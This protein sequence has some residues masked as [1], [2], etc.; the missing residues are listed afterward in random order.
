M[1]MTAESR[2]PEVRAENPQFV[3][4]TVV[5][6]SVVALVCLALCWSAFR[7]HRTLK[8]LQTDLLRNQAANISATVELAGRDL[9]RISSFEFQ[10]RIEEIA[11]EYDGLAELAVIDAGRRVL[12]HTDPG[13]LGL[14]FEAPGLEDL[15]NS[16]K[17]YDER[18]E[19]REGERVCRILLPVHLGSSKDDVPTETEGS[20]NQVGPTFSIASISL[21]VNS[22]SFVARQG[23]WNLLLTLSTC[24]LLLGVTFYYFLALKRSLWM[25]AVEAREKQWALLGR[26]SAALAHDI[27][28]PLGSIKGLAQLLS[29]KP[30]SEGRSSSYV[31]TIVKEA[32]RLEKLVGDLLIFAKPKQPQPR[33]FPLGQILDD[34]AALFEQRFQMTR[35][36]MTVGDESSH[37]SLRTDYDLLKRVLINLAENSLQAMSEGGTLRVSGRQE[38]L[39]KR[40]VLCSLRMREKVFRWRVRR[41]S[42]PFFRPAPAA[43]AWVWPSPGRSLNGLAVRSILKTGLCGALRAPLFSRKIHEQ[44]WGSPLDSDC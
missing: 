26:M 21:F 32:E 1:L 28:N 18:F 2:Q 23:Q 30:L 39:L 41:F 38:P 42:S 24:G 9:E 4:R 25:E 6:G 11:A 31:E 37:L 8:Q 36:Q 34:V 27:R 35:V 17:I 33:S 22:V 3:R 16:R 10:H 40:V 19:T 29:E 13:K 43:P 12:A 7:T 20:S 5:L 14:T 15:L 44:I